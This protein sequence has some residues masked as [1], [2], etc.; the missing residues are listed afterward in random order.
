[1]SATTKNLFHFDESEMSKKIN[2][3]A[4]PN[5]TWPRQW[6]IDATQNA[7]S[8]SPFQALPIEVTL[9]IFRHLSVDELCQV[10]LVCRRL[11]MIADQDELWKAKCNSE[12]IRSPVQ[13]FPQII[14][15]C[16]QHR[17]SYIRSH[18]RICTWIGCM[19]SIFEIKNGKKWKPSTKN[20]VAGWLVA[21]D[22]DHLDIQ[23]DQQAS[24]VLNLSVDSRPIQTRAKTCKASV[25]S[26]S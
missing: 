9:Q 6:P 8:E 18:T 20:G 15:L 26:L 22:V 13:F 17:A 11:K 2:E 14:F 7:L 16:S 25:L 5:I 1:M 12:C 3:R 10:S 4:P 24:L 19:R 23:F 21:C